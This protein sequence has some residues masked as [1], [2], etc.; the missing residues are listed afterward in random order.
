YNAG[1]APDGGPIVQQG[2]GITAEHVQ[3]AGADNR[4]PQLL[5]SAGV[6]PARQGLD[7]AGEYAGQSWDD[8]RSEAR[9]LWDQIRSGYAR[10]VDQTDDKFMQK[11]IKHALGRPT[12]RVILDNNDNII[13]NT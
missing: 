12:T 2:D 13:L 3:A 5:V 1:L 9:D 8:T 6:G 11:R 10:L 7:S 4:L